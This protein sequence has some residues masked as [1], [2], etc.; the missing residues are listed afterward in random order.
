MSTFIKLAK[1]DKRVL[2]LQKQLSNG[3]Y[4]IDLEALETEIDSL[5][6]NRKVRKLKT[7]EI[8]SSFQK[9]FIDA[10]LQNQA[11][12]SRLVEI[13]VK[14]FRIA[15]RLEEHLDVIKPYL[16]TQY[17]DSLAKFKTVADKNAAINNVLEKPMR[18]LQKLENLD[19]VLE[20]LIKDIDQCSFAL[21]H[22]IDAMGFNRDKEVRF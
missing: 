8:I 14:N 20:T 13:K 19:K 2:A 1:N 17:A 15:A 9:K 22:L 7:E 21:K 18:F 10:A 16:R 12:R 4:H 5:H 6:M 11:F 3:L